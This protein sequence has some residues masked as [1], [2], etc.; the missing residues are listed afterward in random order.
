MAKWLK[1]LYKDYLEEVLEEDIVSSVNDT[2]VVIGGVY[3]GS[4]RSIDER[5][6]NKPLFFL[7]VDKID[8]E[9][10]EVFKVSDHYEFATSRDVLL[11]IPGLTVMVEV[12][13]NFYLSED[14]IKRFVL[15]HQLKSQ[16]VQDILAFR[17]G[18]EPSRPLRIGV[19]PIYD[20]DI[21]NKFN[22]EEF[23]QIEDFHLRIFALLCE[24]EPEEFEGEAFEEDEGEPIEEKWLFPLRHLP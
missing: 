3:F 12:G 4:L 20:E 10:Y 11:D 18:E 23:R 8:N 2:P 6:P 9:L 19:T 24:E 15:I 14:E 22:Q 13:N 7:I 16:D 21:R 17:D 1:E 5:K